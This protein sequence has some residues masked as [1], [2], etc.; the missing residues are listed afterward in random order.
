[1]RNNRIFANENFDWGTKNPGSAPG[2][3]T[4]FVA[5]FAL[6]FRNCFSI[7]DI[8]FAKNF[9]QLDRSFY[10]RNWKKTWAM[11]AVHI[12]LVCSLM[13]AVWNT[14]DGLFWRLRRQWQ[15]IVIVCIYYNSLSVTFMCTIF[16]VNRK[17]VKILSH[18]L[19]QEVT[20][21]WNHKW[22]NVTNVYYSFFFIRTG[23]FL[24][25]L[26]VFISVPISASKCSPVLIL[27]THF[28]P[29]M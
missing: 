4:V 14:S 23:N 27:C 29:C 15:I 24:L 22:Q 8:A 13:R 7:N 2:R 12:F 11:H 6:L 17:S 26:N 25:R 18:D 19:W 1:M 10:I 9:N 28:W 5:K 16:C 21:A 3:N 20:T